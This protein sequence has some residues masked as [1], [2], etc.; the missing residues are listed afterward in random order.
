MKAQTVFSLCLM[1]ALMFA[2][3]GAPATEAK[4]PPTQTPPAVAEKPAATDTPTAT[5][6]QIPTET[7]AA[8]PRPLSG[9]NADPQRVEFQ[10]A[11]GKRLV[12]YYYPSKYADAP[13]MILMHWAGGDLC[14]WKALAPWM[15]NRA[16]ESPAALERCKNSPTRFLPD[17]YWLDL[18]QLPAIPIETSIAVFAFDFRDY[19]E[20]EAGMKSRGDWAKDA[21]AAFETAATFEGIDPTRIAAMG[22]SIGADGA[23][24][25]CLLYNQKAGGGCAG[26]LSLSPGSY[27]NMNYAE[28]VTKLAETPAW[29]LAADGDSEA[30][31]TCK[32]ASGENYFS[33]I[34]AG[35]Y[36]GMTLLRP[37]LEPLPM[38]LIQDFMELVFGEALK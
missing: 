35:V 33:Q 37:E 8:P 22:A 2:A 4:S 30:A 10:A 34:Y 31:P 11:D 26:A 32:S 25:G 20:S 18:A 7:P 5:P 38:D 3:C 27:L 17:T 14:D 28:V 24:D 12:G 13:L 15:Q 16:D 1:S 36:H 19:G 9:L 6:T 29:C 23:P 21:L